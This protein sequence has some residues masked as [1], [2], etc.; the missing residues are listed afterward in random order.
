MYKRQVHFFNPLQQ[1]RGNIRAFFNRSAHIALPPLLHITT[2]D[3]ELVG[4]VLGLAGLVTQGG[5]APRGDRTGAA[6]RGLALTTAVGV[7]AGVHDGTTNGGTPAHVTLAAGLTDLDVLM[8]QVAHLTDA[9]L[10]YTS[11]CV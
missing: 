10:L 5:L 4:A 3:N 9:C 11:R 1:L 2:L 6:H 7:V 8:L